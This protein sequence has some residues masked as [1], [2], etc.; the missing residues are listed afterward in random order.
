MLSDITILEMFATTFHILN[1]SLITRQ[2]KCALEIETRSLTDTINNL[3]IFFTPC[4][5]G[6]LLIRTS[7]DSPKSIRYTES[8]L[9]TEKLLK[10]AIYG[11]SSKFYT[12]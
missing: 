9:Q 1:Y 12:S 10:V 7:Y 2:S 11:H 4:Y 3:V 5:H 6:H 8:R